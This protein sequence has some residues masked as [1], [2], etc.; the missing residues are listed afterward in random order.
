MG[1]LVFK[2]PSLLTLHS[3]FVT[4]LLIHHLKYPNFLNPTG[5]AHIFSFSLLKILYFLWDPPDP[6]PEHHTR[7][8]IPPF[9]FPI[10]LPQYLDTCSLFL[11]EYK[12]C[13]SPTPMGSSGV[14]LW[15]YR[16]GACNLWMSL[17]LVI[18]GYM[19]FLW[20]GLVLVICGYMSFLCMGLVLVISSLIHWFSNPVKRKKKKEM[21]PN[22][23]TQCEKERK[24]KKENPSLKT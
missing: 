21:Q 16:F 4:H 12:Q 7:V 9:F 20:M 24:K 13:W 2:K 8:Y 19:G 17:V 14:N 22:L 23:E 15:V 10:T 11:S 18:C 1:Y 6:L 5:L 3:I